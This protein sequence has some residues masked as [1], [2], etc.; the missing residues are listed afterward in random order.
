MT[1]EEFADLVTDVLDAG[2]GIT[3]AYAMGVHIGEAEQRSRRAH[4]AVLAAYDA[5]ALRIAQ[6]EANIDYW[7]NLVNDLEHNDIYL[8][9][10]AYYE[11]RIAELE[12]IGDELANDL[13][14]EL[15]ARYGVERGVHP[16]MASRYDLD[17]APVAKWRELVGGEP[18]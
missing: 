3:R 7:R 15:G 4:V 17:M 18:S 5:Q 10:Q 2:R 9:S 14:A 11:G 1:R 12:A 6:L 13:E 16:A 8:D